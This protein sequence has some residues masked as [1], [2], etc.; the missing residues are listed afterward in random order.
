[1]YVRLVEIIFN[2]DY[3]KEGVSHWKKVIAPSQSSASG[4]LESLLLML[5]LNLWII[6]MN[7]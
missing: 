6:L 5:L 2:K 3:E 4:C 1:M 7:I